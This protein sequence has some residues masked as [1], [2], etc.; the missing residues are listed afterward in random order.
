MGKSGNNIRLIIGRKNSTDN[1]WELTKILH[2]IN[3]S[4]SITEGKNDFVYTGASLLS[5]VL[6]LKNQNISHE[7]GSESGLF[8]GNNLKYIYCEENHWF[9]KSSVIRCDDVRMY[10]LRK[11]Y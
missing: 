6:S 2:T 7:R 10:R 5:D 11:I 8:A 3:I 9:D 4:H 1:N